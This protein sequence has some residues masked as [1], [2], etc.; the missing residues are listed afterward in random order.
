M[1]QATTSAN[2]VDRMVRAARLDASL[3]DEV[4]ADLTAN[5]Q[6]LTVVA[7]AAVASGIGSAIGAVMVGRG[8]NP[9]GALI[10]G[11]LMSFIMW[12]VWSY[13]A[14]FVGTRMFKGTATYGEVLRTMG[15]AYSPG[16]LQVLNFIP[17]LGGL[18]GLVA[19][20][21]TLV[22]GFIALRQSLDLDNGNTVATIVVSFI[23]MIVV[24]VVLSPVFAL[25]GL[26]A[27]VLGA[28]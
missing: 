9:V 5:S 21:W 17:V 28:F 27:A 2:L 12:A 13:V 15:F 1:A 19:A 6:A 16:V 20:V 22:T 7:V 3:Y 25:I 8:T 4:E 26:G 18:I 24:V 23:A 10:G 14:F 11:V